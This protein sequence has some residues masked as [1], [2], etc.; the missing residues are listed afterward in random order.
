MGEEKNIVYAMSL[1]GILLFLIVIVGGIYNMTGAG[2]VE[3]PM[4]I[5]VSGDDMYINTNTVLDAGPYPISDAGESGVIIINASHITLTCSNTVIY[6]GG[7]GYGIYA[8]NKTNITITGCTLSNFTAGIYL[9]GTAGAITASTLTSNTIHDSTYGFWLK[10][11][12]NSLFSDNTIY[13]TSLSAFYVSQSC[14]VDTFSRNLIRDNTGHGINITRLQSAPHFILNN[15]IYN[16]GT[17]S[18]D[19]D[20]IHIEYPGNVIKNNSI[21]DDGIKILQAN[22]SEIIDNTFTDPEDNAICIVDSKYT[23]ISGNIINNNGGTS[24]NLTNNCENNTIYNNYLNNPSGINAKD[25]GTNFWN[26]T[27]TSAI[28]IIGGAN[29][30]GNFWNDY[31]GND[32]NGDGIGDTNLPHTSTNNIT[33]GGDYLPL[34]CLDAD[35]D[36]YSPSP[37]S[38]AFC[39]VT[40]CDDTNPA[41]NPGT[42]EV[43][44]NSI[45]DDCDGSVDE[46][47]DT[48]TSTSS[49]GRPTKGVVIKEEEE[50]GPVLVPTD[51][52]LFILI[53]ESQVLKDIK[54]KLKQ[55][56]TLPPDATV[57]TE[58]KSLD[59]CSGFA[60]GKTLLSCVDI[61][62]NILDSDI[63]EVI[64]G[65]KVPNVLL[66]SRRIDLDTLFAVRQ[67]KKL[68]ISERNSD[69]SF[70]YIE[71]I[72]PGLST[73]TMAGDS[74][75]ELIVDMRPLQIVL[76]FLAV[77]AVLWILMLGW[78]F[79][80]KPKPAKKQITWHTPALHNYIGEGKRRGFGKEE[81]KKELIRAGWAERHVSEELKKFF[82]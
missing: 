46:G 61:S 75:P 65:Y 41:R 81:I 10:Y 51:G 49:K 4:R 27:N 66:A 70:T 56:K 22:Q 8:H 80:H 59:S 50:K 72:S 57:D 1:V 37:Y 82:R 63:E 68:T 62:S 20:A 28:N 79:K 74:I 26:I 31:S 73:F 44:G 64:I 33:A 78:Y 69:D 24:I 11:V 45:D 53:S 12:I 34:L 16:T 19:Y 71:V 3:P 55:G 21:T 40:D 47:C 54:I 77:S 60:P 13:A 14:A 5:P 39:L 36:G 67:D 38:S 9:N 35:G 6:G 17:G 30:G 76:I 7:S 15:T 25:D 32:T 18:S 43:C 48:T 23:N 58:V 2:T 29:I 52:T 42:A